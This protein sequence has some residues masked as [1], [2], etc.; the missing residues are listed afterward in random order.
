MLH[1][2]LVGRLV[3]GQKLHAVR[4]EKGLSPADPT[5]PFRIGNELAQGKS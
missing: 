1:H 2:G 4:Q 3:F 5:L